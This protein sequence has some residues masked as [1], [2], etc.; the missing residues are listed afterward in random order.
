MLLTAKPAD[1]GLAPC[2][3]LAHV[4]AMLLDLPVGAHVATLAV[5]ADGSTSLYFQQRRWDHRRWRTRVG[6]GGE[7]QALVFVDKITRAFVPRES[8]VPVL[9]G[10]ISFAIRTYDGLRVARNTE[11]RLTKRESPLW[12]V[13]F[14]GQE[15]ITALRRA[16]K[17]TPGG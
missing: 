2:A 1:F 17:G 14:M 16:T 8:P 5:V 7:S 12:P 13:F 10:A 6:A 11:A 9:P 4:W 3:E 15:V